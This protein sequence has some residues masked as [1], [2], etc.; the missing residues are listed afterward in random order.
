MLVHNPPVEIA[1]RFWMLGADAYPFYLYRGA[2]SGTLF[3]GGIGPLGPLVCEQL[4]A[5]N[6]AEG[7]LQQLVI[8][9]AHP[10]HVMAV[11]ALRQACPAVSVMASQAAAQTLGNEKAVSFF[12]RMDDQLADVLT[13]AGAITADQR[14]PAMD[15]PVIAVDRVLQAGDTISV[16]GDVAFRVLATPGHSDCSLSFH[17]P[18]AKLLIISDATG[19]YMPEHRWWWPNYFTDYGAYLDSIRRLAEVGAEVLCLSHN[20]AIRGADDVA[21]YLDGAIAAT[22]AYHARIVDAA[23][24]GQ[25]VREIAGTLGADVYEKTQL[26]PLEFFQKNCS[27]LVKNSLR[28]EGIQ[29]E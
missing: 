10:D 17:E 11:P 27:I 26:M 1:D 25:S 19:F 24:D 22:E 29:A 8:T 23:R 3:E 18:A 15:Q 5:L 4:R 21:D 6:I 13:A 9:H 20:G 14:R 12:C 7:Y 16:D 28:H 2:D